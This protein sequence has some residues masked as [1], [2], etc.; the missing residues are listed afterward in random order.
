MKMNPLK[1]HFDLVTFLQWQL[2]VVTMQMQIVEHL[3]FPK[4]IEDFL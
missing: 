4:D 1:C 2:M 3:G